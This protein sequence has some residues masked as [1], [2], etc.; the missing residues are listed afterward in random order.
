MI[1]HHEAITTANDALQSFSFLA[2]SQSITKRDSSN[3]LNNMSTSC[4]ESYRLFKQ[5]STAGE[6]EG[7]SSG[8]AVASYLR[9]AMN[10]CN[11]C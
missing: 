9:C 2:N 7:F 8:N 10:G 3:E 6:V 4:R 5:C 1:H 11:S